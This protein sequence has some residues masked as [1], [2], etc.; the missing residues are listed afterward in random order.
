MAA[1]YFENRLSAARATFE[2]FVRALPRGRSYLIAAGLAQAL[3]YLKNLRFSEA[4][5][6]YLR[7]HAAFKQVSGEFFDYLAQ[8]RFRGDVWA[9]EEGAVCFAN[10]PLL[11]VEA[12]IIEAQLIETFLLATVNFQ[13][14]IASKASRLVAAAQ[15]RGVIEFGTRRAHGSEAG[16]LAARAAYLAGCLGTSNVEAGHLFSIPTF[17]TMAHSF[18]MSFDEERDA[19]AAFLQVFPDT[20]T[21][22]VDTNDT[23]AAVEMLARE[24]AAPIPAIRL[25]SGDL[26]KLSLAARDILDG[27]GM[28]STQIVASNDL[29]EYRI[30]ELLAAGARIDSFGVGT[31]LATS[32]DHAALSGV[33]KLVSTDER[34]KVKMKMK[35]SLEKATYPGAKQVWRRMDEA[36]KY[37]EDRL[38]LADESPP[39]EGDWRALLV[40]VMK[41]GEVTKRAEGATDLQQARA[42]ARQERERLPDELLALEKARDYPLEISARL[43]EERDRL[44]ESSC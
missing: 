32:Y 44:R 30:A 20:A 10:E 35:H 16:L 21:I 18:V 3:E 40:Q 39:A 38:A 9:L 13:T 37:A 12:P 29:D 28:T 2:L 43:R 34:G 41:D 22:L 31:Q 24:F 17:G 11:R 25:D 27:A 8:L 23:L 42:R 33:Y 5:I 19:F 36:G 15:G 4:E 7:H 26:L 1:A 6:D 14:M